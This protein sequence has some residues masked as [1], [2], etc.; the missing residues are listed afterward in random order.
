MNASP[1][2]LLSAGAIEPGLLAASDAFR[3]KSGQQIEITWSTAPVIRRRIEDGQVYDVVIAPDTAIHDFAR[4]AKIV[5]AAPVYIG[6]VGIGIVTRSSVDISFVSS[7]DALKTCL[8][9][10]DSV[11]FNR[12]SSGL[13]VETLLRKLNIYAEI[14]DR[15]VRTDNGPAMMEHLIAGQ[16]RELGFGAIVEIQMFCDRGLK[17]VGPLPP[18]LQHWTTYVAAPMI[19]APNA[20]GAQSV[21]RFLATTRAKAAFAAHGIA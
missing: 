1:V 17:L 15:I 8:C 12:A 19:A 7:T 21:L 20:A 11:V 3:A 10:A 5:A 13:Y 14:E 18:E 16:G 6:R 9:N 2:S 4:L